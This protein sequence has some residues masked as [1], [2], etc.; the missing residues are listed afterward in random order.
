M[1]QVSEPFR[2]AAILR[3]DREEP[4]SA[5]DPITAAT[6]AIERILAAAHEAGQVEA[7]RILHAVTALLSATPRH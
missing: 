4:F 2:M 7:V 3:P 6:T 5:T 1:N